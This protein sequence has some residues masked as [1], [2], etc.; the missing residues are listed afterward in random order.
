M[1]NLPD[2][3]LDAVRILLGA[4]SGK[5]RSTD[6]L[7]AR[8]VRYSTD[9]DARLLHE[10]V[11]GVLRHRMALEVV[12]NEMVAGGLRRVSPAIREL[13]FTT[14]YQALH[15]RRIP[16]YAIVSGSVEAARVIQGEGAARL[17]NAVSRAIVQN[18]DW[19]RVVQDL[20]A[21][22]RWS[23]P[24]PIWKRIVAVVGHEPTEN[25]MEM[26][27]SP[28]P[29]TLR[30]NQKWT[31]RE[32]A[33]LFLH[34][35]GIEAVPTTYADFGIVLTSRGAYRKLRL[36]RRAWIP[37]RFLPQD[38]ASQLAVQVLDPKP[39]EKIVD[40][41]AGV[42]I[43]TTDILARARGARVLAV[44]I[45]LGRLYK[46]KTLCRKSH[47]GEP[48]FLAA[49]AT[50][51]PAALEGWADAVLVDA[52]C[53]GIGTIRRRPE[54]R[55]LRRDDDF[56]QARDK[57]VNIIEA[58]LRLLRPKG[59]L[60]YAVCSFAP[61]EGPEV[62]EKVLSRN[63]QV[64]LGDVGLAPPIGRPDGTAQTLPWRENMDGFFFAKF[65]KT[66]P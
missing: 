31:T 43:K 38:E 11:M 61:E 40:L 39:G 44:D 17:V 41:C 53:T 63:R 16:E 23:L 45:D 15:L 6:L 58:A 36:S 42:G 19:E 13:L 56:C 4:M 47:V 29:V 30:V 49:D 7:E 8:L 62:V 3:R 24:E 57:Q 59:R 37:E 64:K 21:K 18:R 65:L 27:Q 51:L 48:V 34:K 12:L 32:Q 28:A 55:Y 54:V 66:K 35:L 50:R 2:P 10:L 1:K 20:E 5:A 14:A 26:V 22:I 46:A 52:P 25:E 9:K 33:L 60:V